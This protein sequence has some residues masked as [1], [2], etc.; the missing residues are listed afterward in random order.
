MKRSASSLWER[1]RQKASASLGNGL[2]PDQYRRMFLRKNHVLNASRTAAVGGVVLLGLLAGIVGL[3]R[4]WLRLD[5]EHHA[6]SI[7][8]SIAFMAALAVLLCL[9]FL[10]KKRIIRSARFITLVNAAT[11]AVCIAVVVWASVIAYPGPESLLFYAIGLFAFALFFYTT[12]WQSTVFYAGA[13]AA[14][15]ALMLVSA[16]PDGGVVQ[17]ILFT[18]GGALLAWVGSRMLYS[19]RAGAFMSGVAQAELQHMSLTDPLLGISNRRKFDIAMQFSWNYCRREQ[20]PISLAMID[21]DYFKRYNDRFGHSR[22][23]ECLKQVTAAIGA[24][25]HRES[26]ELARVG[27]EELAFML[28]LTPLEDAARIMEKA[29]LAVAEL[30]IENPDAPGGILTVS[31]GV[32]GTV[33]G[34]GR[35][36]TS[37]QELYQA[38][39]DALYNAK[40]QGR[41]RICLG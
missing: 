6:L 29:R 34:A 13:H 17:S 9:Y 31:A 20:K 27:G 25:I 2:V 1:I 38:A 32:A 39:D 36:I 3:L 18:T 26:D 12:I 41:N 33:P 21:I 30:K 4:G 23:D 8:L 7:A 5:A 22:G 15:V 28:P 14:F 11:V 19:A 10:W 37:P 35:R 40:K 16:E 24:M